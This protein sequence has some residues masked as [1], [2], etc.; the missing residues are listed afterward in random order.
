M[1]KKILFLEKKYKMVEP[2]SED[3]LALIVIFPPLCVL[4]VITLSF[5]I[6]K[7]V[8]VPFK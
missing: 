1:K 7:E 5:C 3:M 8:Y 2:M 4:V 6:Y